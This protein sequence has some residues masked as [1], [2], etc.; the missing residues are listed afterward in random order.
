MARMILKIVDVKENL[1]LFR[2]II[3]DFRFDE[4]QK[5]LTLT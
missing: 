5:K 1:Q 3:F 4:K 2:F